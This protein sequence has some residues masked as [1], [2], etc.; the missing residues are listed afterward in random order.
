[1]R[2]PVTRHPARRW[3]TTPFVL[4]VLGCL[5]LAGWAVWSG[6]VLDGT[7]ARAVRTSSVYA[8]PGVGLD[9]PA[10]QQVIGNRRLVVVLL[11]PGADLSGTC[12]KVERAASGTLVLLLDRDGD[13][14]DTYGCSSLPD[15][16]W[17]QKNFG[18]AMV[19]ESD[20]ADGIDEFVD[21]PLE[22]VKMIAVNYDQLVKAG[23][24][25][26]D[27]RTVSPSLPR[28]L[29]AIAAVAAVIAGSALLFAAGR[30]AG[31]IAAVRRDRRDRATAS[32][33]ALSAT[34]AVVAQQIIDLDRRFGKL[35]PYREVAAAYTRLLDDIAA[36]DRREETDYSAL[37]ERAEALSQRL[38][39]LVA[40]ADAVTSPSGPRA[41]S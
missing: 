9:V 5:V 21:R 28:Y 35:T 26:D 34:A 37:T 40:R 19:A 25:P 7:V 13:R 38:R 12:H 8:A 11:G 39:A 31:R 29:V 10:A 30:R 4:A 18:K 6:G 1:M 33:T 36:A 22:A 16:G 15:S 17:N 3:L 41:A 27:A 24:V 32:R 20:I 23:I 2:R 14:Y